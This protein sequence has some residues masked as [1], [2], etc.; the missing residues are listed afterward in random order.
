MG[1][2]LGSLIANIFMTSL[3]EDLVPTLKSCLCN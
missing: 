1:S 3:K 2:Q